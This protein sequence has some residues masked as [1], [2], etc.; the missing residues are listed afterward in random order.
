MGSAHHSLREHPIMFG[1][2]EEV[3]ALNNTLLHKNK[4]TCIKQILLFGGNNRARTYDPLLV[5]QML[6]QLSYAPNYSIKSERTKKMERMTRLELA[7]STLARWR[8]TR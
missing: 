4:R 8:S 5:R 6:S 7:T 2:A 1:F 3:R